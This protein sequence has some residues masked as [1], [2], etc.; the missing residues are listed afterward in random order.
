MVEKGD[1]VAFV[2]F[3]N[4]AVRLKDLEDYTALPP[5]KRYP[6]I[7]AVKIARL[8]VAKG[9][10]GKNI[11]T[12]L[13]NMIKQMFMTHNRTGCRLLTVD[14]YN[15]PE[16]IAFYQKNGFDFLREKEKKREHPIMYFDL[17]SLQ[18]D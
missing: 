16:V 6:S 14:A 5:E 3:C 7:P 10:Q 1:P 17:I 8:A 13:V 9:L 12:H 2:S 18:L 11:G 15:K 4:D